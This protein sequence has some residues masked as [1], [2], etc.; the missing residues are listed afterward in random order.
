MGT[1]FDHFSDTAHHGFKNLPEDV[2]AKRKLLKLT[3]EKYGFKALETEWHW[4]LYLV[5]TDKYELLDLL[6]S[7]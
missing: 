6:Q 3:M 5:P 4:L 2:L 1:G 7:F